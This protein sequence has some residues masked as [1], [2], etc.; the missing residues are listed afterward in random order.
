[1]PGRSRCSGVGIQVDSLLPPPGTDPLIP[2]F[3][4]GLDL[5]DRDIAAL[6]SDVNTLVFVKFEIAF[7]LH[8]QHPVL[9]FL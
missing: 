3:H 9:L 7:F 8:P 5:V 6:P 2:L 4:A 1:M